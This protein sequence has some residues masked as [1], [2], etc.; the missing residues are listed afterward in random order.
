[1]TTVSLQLRRTTAAGDKLDSV[2]PPPRPFSSTSMADK[3]RDN[4]TTTTRAPPTSD[5][6]ELAGKLE[7]LAEEA[8]GAEKTAGA[9]T[10]AE[11]QAEN[12][13]VREENADLTARLVR[14]E[15]ALRKYHLRSLLKKEHHRYLRH[16]WD[17]LFF[18][19]ALVMMAEQQEQRRK[20]LR[21]IEDARAAAAA[22]EAE[23]EPLLDD[24]DALEA[25]L[26][27]VKAAAGVAAR[28]SDTGLAAPLSAPLPLVSP[29]TPT[30]N[31]TATAT[32]VDPTDATDIVE[33]TAASG[34][35]GG[36][37]GA[38]SQE[39][40]VAA[41][42][43]GSSNYEAVADGTA[44]S[45]FTD[46]A[47]SFCSSGV[48][49]MQAVSPDSAAGASPEVEEVASSEPA[50][51]AESKASELASEN[52]SRRSVG[53]LPATEL[54]SSTSPILSTAGEVEAAGQPPAM[55][56]PN[57]PALST[58]ATPANA[59]TALVNENPAFIGASQ[60]SPRAGTAAPAA[61][62]A[63]GNMGGSLT[64]EREALSTNSTA[65][66]ATAPTGGDVRPESSMIRA[67]PESPVAAEPTGSSIREAAANETLAAGGT[68]TVEVEGV[69]T[70]PISPTFPV[71][72]AASEVE[73]ASQPPAIP[74]L[75]IQAVNPP[76]FQANE[77]TALVKG[78]PASVAVLQTAPCVST[79]APAA[80]PV[81]G[82][83]GGSFTT[84]A[85][86]S[87]TN[88]TASLVAAAPAADVR[89][90]AVTSESTAVASV[91]R[92]SGPRNRTTPMSRSPSFSSA[93][94]SSR[95]RETAK[96]S[97]KTAN[98]EATSETTID[99]RAKV[100]TS[101]ALRRSKWAGAGKASTNP[102]FPT[103]AGVRAA[104]PGRGAATAATSRQ[105]TA[106]S[107]TVPGHPAGSV[108]RAKGTSSGLPSSVSTAAASAS[109]TRTPANSRQRS[110]DLENPPTQPST[111]T[112]P[113]GV[114]NDRRPLTPRRC[115]VPGNG[116][117]NGGQGGDEFSGSGESTCELLSH[118]VPV[119]RTSACQGTRCSRGSRNLLSST[120]GREGKGAGKDENTC[121]RAAA[122]AEAGAGA[123][124][125]VG[126][127]T[128]V[129]RTASGRLTRASS[130][131][132]E[133]SAKAGHLRRGPKKTAAKG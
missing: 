18:R 93:T 126:E 48:Q 33:P 19:G 52:S 57:I 101:T 1:M 125:G 104:Q 103:G 37:Q 68:F 112:R 79:A 21:E 107:P 115:A 26:A 6:V 131:S 60:T 70:E 75:D 97:T 95:A 114:L 89:L 82:T 8:F 77:I 73:A 108:V 81:V 50:G 17:A 20:E 59:I 9:A 39:P 16:G 4:T 109:R 32:A 10:K 11:L 94:V 49:E 85:E 14:A 118:S 22:A 56:P 3:K 117:I 71:S 54:M 86:S 40:P 53:S 83:V 111:R 76:V 121:R 58:A 42:L 102:S 12:S 36:D 80:S 35:G 124:A 67:T 113:R 98:I 88:S 91:S 28:G 45:V 30:C 66:L 69:A 105:A 120:P 25:E 128:P 24:L 34:I 63:V 116:A 55:S 51:E 7:T 99:N 110:R 78:S 47:D 31:G 122:G 87:S 129:S 44:A 38:G 74:P 62:P 41:E 96:A 46:P 100:S 127:E 27:S 106:P 92:S 133:A 130:R 119:S 123:G 72:S 13:A 29:S 15:S 132:T 84:G 90:E 5:D 61:S 23:V 43:T 2:S 65:S 64:T